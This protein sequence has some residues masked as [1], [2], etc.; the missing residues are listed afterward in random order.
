MYTRVNEE[1]TFRKLETLIAFMETG[2]LARAAERLEVS[3]VSVHRAVHSLEVGLCCPLFRHEGRNLHPTDA[4]RALAD[5]ARVVLRTMSEGVRATRELAG[6][7]ANRIRIGALHSLTIHTV[8]QMLIGIGERVPALA[9]ELVLGSSAELHRKLREGAIDAA[10]MA[11]PE[12]NLELV[13]QLLFTDELYF[14][15]HADSRHA[16]EHSID[17]GVCWDEN[18]I[19]LM[20]G[21]STD[22]AL[23]EA[24][25]LAG[26]IPNVVM[27]TSDVFSL[28]N[29][30]SGGIGCTLLPGR[31]REMVPQKVKL[32]PL[33]RSYLLRQSVVLSFLRT[34]ERDPNLLDLLAVCRGL[35]P[36]SHGCAKGVRL[37]RVPEPFRSG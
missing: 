26:F 19:S 1:I 15:T 7:S 3:T 23:A 4:A 18:F 17:L 27:R 11:M 31:V 35:K 9:T 2:N 5:T 36:E 29:L 12:G 34:R 22:K 32:I 16:A 13:S 30:V 10:L 6:Y 25:R 24:F 20:E 37:K 14:A 33:Q 28:M 8:P 21:F